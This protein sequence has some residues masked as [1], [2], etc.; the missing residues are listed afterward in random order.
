[1]NKGAWLRNRKIQERIIVEGNLVLETPSRFGTG[2]TSGLVDIPLLLD[3]LEQKALLSGA[4]LC[5]AL[6]NFLRNWEAGYRQENRKGS[7]EYELFGNQD[8]DLG[9]Q[10]YLIISDSLGE[11]PRRELRDGVAIDAGTRTAAEHKKY[12]FEVMEA[13]AKF[14]LKFEL[15]IEQEKSASLV[16]GLA[17]ALQGLEKGEIRLGGRKK[18]GFGKCSVENWSVRRY[19]L[20]T[21]RGLLAWLDNDRSDVKIGNSILELLSIKDPI[22]DRRSRFCLEAD[23]IVASPLMIRSGFGAGKSADAVHLHSARPGADEPVPI[24]S[25]T[26]LAGVVRA[27]AARIVNTIKPGQEKAFIDAMFGDAEIQEDTTPNASRVT[28]SESQ[29]IQAAPRKLDHEQIQNR[30]KIDRFTGG[31]YETALFNEQPFF[32]QS[33]EDLVRISLE[34]QNPTPAEVGLLLLILKDLWTEDLPVGGES[35]IG[36]GRL[37]GKRAWLTLQ[38]PG[39]QL[40]WEISQAGEELEIKQ[41]CGSPKPL[42]DFVDAW[43]GGRNE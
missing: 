2:D 14:P 34:L 33:T 28:I 35:S 24:L 4:S 32:P 11:K 7:L 38:E 15:L 23:F 22:E 26:S 9:S 42:Q 25:G 16:Q 39:H 27:R 17:L 3:P 43:V 19:D 13:G 18:R 40:K 8:D 29:V 36:R 31:A 30:V 12:D 6:R 1:M 20:K 21:P 10:S 41:T 5:G 37:K